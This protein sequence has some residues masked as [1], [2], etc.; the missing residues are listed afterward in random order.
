VEVDQILIDQQRQIAEDFL[1]KRKKENLH[2]NIAIGSAVF[3]AFLFYI[4]QT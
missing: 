1:V 2:F 3:V 4:C